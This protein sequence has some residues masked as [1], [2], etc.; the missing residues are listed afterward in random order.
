MF[1]ARD[2]HGKIPLMCHKLY[3]NT[4]Y[5]VVQN[6]RLNFSFRH[7]DKD[8]IISPVMF[9]IFRIAVSFQIV[10]DFRRNPGLL[11]ILGSFDIITCV[12]PSNIMVYLGLLEN[13][14]NKLIFFGLLEDI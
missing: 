5:C 8:I 1:C 12:N 3:R 4:R 9:S 7:T 11:E 13:T 14:L 2:H 6:I 10:L